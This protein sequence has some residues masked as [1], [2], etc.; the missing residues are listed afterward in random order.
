MAR[1]LRIDIEDGWYHVTSRGL[2]RRSIFTEDRER[3]HFVDLLEA[4]VEMHRVR[5]HAYVL[6]SNHYHLLLQTPDANLSE[7]MRWLNVSYAVWF[8]RRHQRV[9]PLFQGRFKSIPVEEGLWAWDASLYVHLNP[10]MRKAHGLGKRSRR[11]E[12]RG[13][14]QPDADQ[15]KA[16]LEELRT[17][18]W[19]SYS[20]Y[21]GYRKT[22]DWMET[23]EI[24]QT[25]GKAIRESR[26]TYRSQAKYMLTQGVSEEFAVGMKERLALGTKDFVDRVR[27]LAGNPGREVVGKSRIRHRASFEDAKATVSRIR[28]LSFEEF[29]ALRGDW[30][31][32]LLLW[33]GKHCCGLTHKELG[34]LCG[35]MDYA[36]VTMMIRRFKAMAEKD[37]SLRNRIKSVKEQ[38]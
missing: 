4:A 24:L 1:P 2:E 25:R 26:A 21:A 31:K 32:P 27:T 18:R 12:A 36:A 10:V 37:K 28:K 30:A 14:H 16:R 7:A 13:L 3:Q 35:G 38:L 33:A 20:Y 6:M 23:G 19:S 5:M 11:A 34:D 17:Y 15:A 8:N 29:M 22:P 9:G